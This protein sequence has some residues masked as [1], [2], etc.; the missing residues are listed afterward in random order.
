LKKEE[1]QLDSELENINQELE[2]LRG[3]TAFQ[4]LQK[5]LDETK[6]TMKEIESIQLN[7]DADSQMKLWE[8]L[9]MRIPHTKYTQIKLQNYQENNKR[10]EKLYKQKKLELQK[11]INSFDG[12][13]QKRRFL[14]NEIE[15][16]KKIEKLKDRFFYILMM[17]SKNSK[18]TYREK[19]L[20][21]S[22]KEK[23]QENEQIEK[24]VDNFQNEKQQKIEKLNFKIDKYK[25]ILENN[26]KENISIIQEF[27]KKLDKREETS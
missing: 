11:Y 24:V 18:E 6:A 2:R 25:K 16:L 13:E 3:N 15:A 19:I 1:A 5:L 8:L 7:S 20:K 26:D 27:E 4:N 9:S 14:E 12:S 23:L 22:L 21:E 17:E 10:L